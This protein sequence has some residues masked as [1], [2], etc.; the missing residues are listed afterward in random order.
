MNRK[1]SGD[2]LLRI[3]NRLLFKRFLALTVVL[4]FSAGMIA[5]AGYLL[6]QA[7]IREEYSFIG[8]LRMNPDPGLMAPGAQAS[9]SKYI[10]VSGALPAGISYDRGLELQLIIEDLG[11]V[12]PPLQTRIVHYTGSTDL[13]LQLNDPDAVTGEYPAAGVQPSQPLKIRM[14]VRQKRL[15]LVAMQRHSFIQ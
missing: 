9:G 4:V 8:Y 2:F 1:T 3:M 7:K 15:L 12:V 6:W 10:T 14:V 5:S 13:L 11:A